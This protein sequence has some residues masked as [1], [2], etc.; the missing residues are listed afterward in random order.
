MSGGCAASLTERFDAV[1]HVDFEFEPDAN[2]LPIP[3]CMHAQEQH[4]GPQIALWHD[5]LLR[6]KRAPFGTGPRDLLV[7]GQICLG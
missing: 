4:T 6:L 1:W 5:E 3:V 7:A 2:H